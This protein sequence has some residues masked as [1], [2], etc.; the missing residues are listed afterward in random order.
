MWREGG[1]KSTRHVYI[2][3]MKKREKDCQDAK[4]K[5]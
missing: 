2:I 3:E 1:G 5:E 4:K